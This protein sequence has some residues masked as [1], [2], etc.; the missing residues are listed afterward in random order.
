MRDW[1]PTTSIEYRCLDGRSKLGLLL[2][3]CSYPTFFPLWGNKSEW[4][5][6][7]DG[8][9]HDLVFMK[10]AKFNEYYL[11]LSDKRLKEYSG[12]L[13]SHCLILMSIQRAIYSLPIIVCQPCN[14]PSD[15]GYASRWVKTIKSAFSPITQLT[16]PH[17]YSRSSQIEYLRVSCL[18]S[19]D[20]RGLTE[21]RTGVWWICKRI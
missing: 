17:S 20:H 19:S 9:L 14:P 4:I 18:A 21:R 10:Y 12:L 11:Y 7:R 3:A 2:I 16:C 1:K 15:I 8:W 13:F 6:R 5:K